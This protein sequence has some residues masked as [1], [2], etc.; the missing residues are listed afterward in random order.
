M[1][2]IVPLFDRPEFIPVVAQWNWAEWKDLLPCVSCEAFADDL[3]AHTRRDGVPI[4]FLALDGGV[5]V[6]TSSLIADDLEMRPELTQ[7][8]A[9]LS[10]GRARRASRLGTML[11]KHAVDA[12]H[13]FGIGT[14]YLYTP[15][16]EAY[17]GR[18]GWEFLEATYFFGRAITI[19]RQRLK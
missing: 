12:A 3:R 9:S 17:Y 2:E 6:G 19:M 14:L 7:W 5:P 15:G 1:I 4:T 11:V 8:L 18:L 10:V 13:S 16:Q